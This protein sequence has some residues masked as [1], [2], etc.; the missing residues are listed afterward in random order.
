MTR[1]FR[2]QAKMT[3]AYVEN[4]DRHAFVAHLT[5]LITTF[6]EHPN[7]LVIA[8]GNVADGALVT[9][10]QTATTSMLWPD[11]SDTSVC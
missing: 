6:V 4:A 8:A 7:P 5:N 10:T 2:I 9:H 1:A 3:L 11:Q